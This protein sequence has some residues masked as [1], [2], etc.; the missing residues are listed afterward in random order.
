MD[1]LIKIAAPAIAVVMGFFIGFFYRKYIIDSKLSSA[2]QKANLLLSNAKKEAQT[3]KKE[4]LWRVKR[5][6]KI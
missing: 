4:A 6:F 2:E 5:R 1:L 3:I